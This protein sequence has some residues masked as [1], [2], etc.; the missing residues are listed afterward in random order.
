MIEEIK[1]G[2]VYVSCSPYTIEVVKVIKITK[3]L[4]V[5]QTKDREGQCYLGRF[6][7]DYFTPDQFECLIDKEVAGLK[8]QLADL[9]KQLEGK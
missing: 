6:R 5:F 9:K 8:K 3:R 1:I 4:V 7:R 2:E